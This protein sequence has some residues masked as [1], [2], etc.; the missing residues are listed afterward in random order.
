MGIVVDGSKR[1]T[2][3]EMNAV[4]L[5]DILLVLLVI[6]LIIQH[7]QMGLKA[8][9]PQVAESPSLVS[10]PE[11]VVVQVAADGSLKVNQQPV[12]WEALNGE[13][14]HIFKTRVDR[15]AFIRGDALVEFQAVARAIDIMHT[16][17]VTRVGLMTL[18]LEKSR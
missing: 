12:T 4:P 13:L 15:T 7:P 16:A 11:V 8:D 3:V 9:I 10:Q 2:I 5:I 17:G 18:E 14:E 6:F 1:G